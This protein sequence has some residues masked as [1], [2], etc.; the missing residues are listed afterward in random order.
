MRD[1]PTQADDEQQPPFVAFHADP[2][3]EDGNVIGTLT[4]GPWKTPWGEFES[5]KIPHSELA[6]EDADITFDVKMP[7]P[8]DD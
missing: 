2:V 6:I 8:E 1:K 4:M 3:D 5:V 7:E